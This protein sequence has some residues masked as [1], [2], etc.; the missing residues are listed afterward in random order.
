M[1]GMHHCVQLL[2]EMESDELLPG[3][4]RMVILPIS[5]SQVVKITGMSHQAQQLLIFLWYSFLHCQKGEKENNKLLE[6]G[7]R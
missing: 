3:L 4:G 1:V 6:A 2:V 7:N 5:T